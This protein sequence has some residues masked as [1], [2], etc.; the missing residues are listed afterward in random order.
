MHEV[1]SDCLSMESSYPYGESKMT[2]PVIVPE[3]ST[4]S[5]FANLL[6]A[7]REVLVRSVARWRQWR[8]MGAA[9]AAVATGTLLR[10][11]QLNVKP[12]HSDEGVNGFFLLG[13]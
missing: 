2:E 9:T 7:V 12:L 3:P 1:H 5:H 11:C 8:W 4:T 10:I 13:L 6:G